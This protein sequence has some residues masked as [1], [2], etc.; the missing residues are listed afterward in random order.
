KLDKNKR[1]F[2]SSQDLS[3][4]VGWAMV[5]GTYYHPAGLVRQTHLDMGWKLKL[6][7]GEILP[8]DGPRLDGIE[9]PALGPLGGKPYFLHPQELRDTLARKG[10]AG[11]PMSLKSYI[12]QICCHPT[13]GEPDRLERKYLLWYEED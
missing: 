3:S 5:V 1:Q 6:L 9:D 11:D 2:I 8:E 4:P 10:T 12:E 13:M 7:P